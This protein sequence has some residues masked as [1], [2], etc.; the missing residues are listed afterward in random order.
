MLS[1]FSILFRGLLLSA[2]RSP[3]EDL[4]KCD[5]S[6]ASPALLRFSRRDLAWLLLFREAPY[7]VLLASPRCAKDLCASSLAHLLSFASLL[8]SSLTPFTALALCLALRSRRSLHFV[9][10]SLEFCNPRFLAPRSACFGSL[11]LSLTDSLLTPPHD[12]ARL[13]SLQPTNAPSLR[14]PLSRARGSPRFLIE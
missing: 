1:W 4:H 2:W 11:R 8:G 14:D 12:E 3:Y 13:L 7:C 9:A 6:I 10:S 5:T